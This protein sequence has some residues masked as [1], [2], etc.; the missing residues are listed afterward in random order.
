MDRPKSNTDFRMMALTFKVRDR[1]RPR[2]NLLK[3][4]GIEQGFHV[5]D[6]GCGSGSYIA[7]L[8]RMVGSS[9]RIYALDIHPLAIRM[10]RTIAAKGGL[11]NVETIQSDCLTGLPD[12]S[13]DVV[14]L[15]DVLHT[16]S[17]LQNVLSE[18]YRVLK[19]DGI[20]FVSDHHMDENDII[21]KV[22]NKGTFRLSRKGKKTIGFAKNN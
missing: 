8:A 1:I 12:K 5:L 18:M 15:F 13:V 20:L 2:E 3:E 6:Y 21:L 22:T 16:L 14:L 19:K 17:E 4:V 11:E 7:P 9:G 10:V